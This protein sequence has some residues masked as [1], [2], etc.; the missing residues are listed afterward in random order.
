MKQI[1]AIFLLLLFSQTNL[2]AK[3]NINQLNA[4]GERVGFWVLDE[5]N[6]PVSSKNENK[7]KEGYYFNGR[8]EG[9]WI[10]FHKN[11][12][13][14]RVI[15]EFSDN[16]P[17]GIFFRFDL[18]GD[19]IQAGATRKD[20]LFQPMIIA[21]TAA[22]DCKINF[23]NKEMVAGQVFFHKSKWFTNRNSFQFWEEREFNSTKS[24]DAKIDFSWLNT[25][26]GKIESAFVASRKLSAKK[27][28]TEEEVI[29]GNGP[30]VKSPKMLNGGVFHPN[31][32]NKVYNFQDEIWIDGKFKN[33]QLWDGKEFIYDTDGVLMKVKVFKNGKFIS[34]GML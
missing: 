18:N 34:N 21:T 26:Y 14:P 8:K 15:G 5:Q 1:S 22:F 28:V 32:W 19:M 31:G 3:I 16:R 11:T 4:S 25:N 10:L 12:S 17:K 29:V 13:S 27:E 20:L 7:S 33:A 2:F 6:N 23:K 30:V 9:V 24:K